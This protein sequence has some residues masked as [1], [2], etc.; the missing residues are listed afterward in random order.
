MKA[1]PRTTFQLFPKRYGFFPYLFL[2]YLVLPLLM[3]KNETG[4]KQMIGY[5]LLVVFIVA[6]RQ[7]YMTM[8]RRAFHYWL[9]L[10]MGI[11]FILSIFYNPNFLY[12][13]FFPANFIGWY[14]EKKPFRIALIAFAMLMLVPVFY[15]GI[16]VSPDTLF[17]L[18]FLLI[19]LLSPFGIRSMAKKTE[20]E[21]KLDQANEKIKELVKREERTRIARDL[22][23][24]LGHTLS[25]ITLKSQ[26]VNRLI[27]KNPE[28]AQQE[29][30]EIEQ[31]S[32][33]ALKQ[34][35]ELVSNMR[36]STIEEELLAAEAIL[37]TAG[38]HVEIQQDP[39]LVTIPPLI[40]NIVGLCLREAVTNVIKHSQAAG[41]WITIA[42]TAAGLYCSVRDDGVGLSASQAGGNGLKGIEERLVL[43]D[44]TLTLSD[45]Q[46]TLFIIEVPIIEKEEREGALL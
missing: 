10:Q 35:R 19:M 3:L 11:V 18:P 16:L 38:I 39:E 4:W 41:C 40:H 24:T 9:A 1:N 8:G 45:E 5:S 14:H 7:L 31:T 37:K 34:V 25:L 17:F 21:M 32:R 12:S 29:A 6:Y 13:G 46:G 36:A 15:Y 22:H 2:I 20:L 28:R 30:K 23:D 44:G 33:A 26:L 43:I 27:V 42:R